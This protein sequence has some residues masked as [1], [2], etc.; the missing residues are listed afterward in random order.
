MREVVHVVAMA[1]SIVT[2]V[3][4][5]A[6]SAQAQLK[7]ESPR[8]NA[9]VQVE[10]QTQPTP[11][12]QEEPPPDL[13]TFFEGVHRMIDRDLKQIPLTEELIKRVIAHSKERE[14][15]RETSPNL[16]EA[17]EELHS[18]Y[19][20]ASYDE[21]NIVTDNIALVLAGIDPAT[22][23]YVGLEAVAK[24]LPVIPAQ[25]TSQSDLER[26]NEVLRL[27]PPVQY[28]GNIDLIVRY[29]EELGAIF[30]E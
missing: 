16:E 22:K 2:G 12:S 20:F 21:Y 13:M 8:K 10:Q 27:A 19:G 26:L 3:M 7:P 1:A 24:I 11:L 4:V 5:V 14:V 9:P 30:T 18:R 28:K 17:F 6:F 23:R 25:R 29:Y 15:V